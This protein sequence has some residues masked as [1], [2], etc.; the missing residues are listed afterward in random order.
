MKIFKSSLFIGVA[1]VLLVMGCTSQ[2]SPKQTQKPT[3][4]RSKKQK[5]LRINLTGEPST[6]DPRKA[7]SLN[8]LNVIKMVMDGLTRI[9][10]D[11]QPATSLA[12]E[13]K[14]SDDKLTYT[15]T[16]QNTKW[17]NGEALTAHDFVYAWKKTISP[18][19]PSDNAS[20]LYV[21]KNAELIKQG[22]LPNSLLGVQA[23]DDKT[24]VIQLEKPTP[25][26]LELLASPSF[27]PICA[28]L[29][30]ENPHWAENADT[31]ISCGPFK[32]ETWKHSD[33][34]EVVKNEDYWDAQHVKLKKISMVMVTAETGL[35][36]YENKELDWEGSPLSTIPLDALH[37]LKDQG[38]L[39]TQSS[40][41]TSFIRTNTLKAPFNSIHVRKAFAIGMHRQSLIE[42]VLH[43]NASYASG[44]VPVFLGL[45]EQEYFQ[46]GDECQ[47]KALIE[48]ALE[49]KEISKEDLSHI[50]LSFLSNEKNYRICQAL[51]EQWKKAFN[52]DI[53]LEAIEGKVYFNRVSQKDFQLALGSWVADFRDPINFLEVFK[54]KDIGTNNTSWENNEYFTKLEKSYETPSIEERNTLLKECEQILIQEM[55]I[56]PIWHGTMHYVKNDSVKNVV[57][58]DCGGIDFKWA[59]LDK[60]I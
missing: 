28:K 17:S 20:L 25:Y 26:L 57:V 5:T 53:Q 18:H 45:R 9:N 55:P 6:L 33:S 51:Q 50:T 32:L 22:K 54:T 24:L 36:M 41:L 11:G 60:K 56:I 23:L 3:S 40:L 34:I 15:V 46:D 13:I 16:L 48:K 58:S 19:F 30:K 47:A 8:D 1:F 27:F 59:F 42:H 31:Y 21:I 12:E 38:K 2:S 43:G 52:I 14:I 7:R 39:N 4:S 29:D 37:S 44:L 49:L 10:Y 35:S